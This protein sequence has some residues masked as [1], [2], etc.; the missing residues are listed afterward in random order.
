MYPDV[1]N[2]P[3]TNIHNIIFHRQDQKEWKNHTLH[4]D[5]VTG[6]KRTFREFYERVIDGATALASPAS[7]EGLGLKGEDGEIVGILAENCMVRFFSSLVRRLRLIL[8]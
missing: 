1:P 7:E 2:I 3:P 6:K 8:P 5:A 4:I